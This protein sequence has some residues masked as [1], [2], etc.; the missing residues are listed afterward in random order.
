MKK[1]FLALL[2]GMT[3]A[4]AFT[5]C[6]PVEDPG[7]PSDD[8]KVGTEG[9]SYQLLE[10]GNYAVSVGTA[11]KVSNIVIP[12]TYNGKRVTV[13]LDNGFADC[14]MLKSITVP[15]S[16]TYIGDSAFDYCLELKSVHISDIEAWCNI[17]FHDKT[18]NPLYSAFSSIHARAQIVS[19][20]P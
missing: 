15:D 19:N 16:I 2:L 7:K 18:S 12:S 20:A 9:L 10:D 3:L 8:S 13:I 11:T 17:T 6:G 1:L 4:L 5:S 14:T